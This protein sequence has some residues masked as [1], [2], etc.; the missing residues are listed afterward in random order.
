MF[1]DLKM[2]TQEEVAEIINVSRDTLIMLREE[3]LIRAIKTGKCYMFPQHEIL[4]FQKKYIGFDVSNRVNARKAKE[5][6]T[7]GTVTD[8]LI[9]QN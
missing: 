7:A 4:H 8:E 1:E 5:K 2:A 6:V 3:G 9:S